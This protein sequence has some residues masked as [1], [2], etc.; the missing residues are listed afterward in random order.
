MVSL[1]ERLALLFGFWKEGI[2]MKMRRQQKQDY[3]AQ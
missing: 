2:G 3:E 1:P